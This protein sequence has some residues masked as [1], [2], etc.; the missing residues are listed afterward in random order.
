[1]LME[2]FYQLMA[3]INHAALVGD[4]TPDYG[5]HMRQLSELWPGARFLHI[6]RDGRDTA[7]S[8][9]G[10]LSFCYL[11]ASGETE[12]SKA[13]VNKAFIRYRQQVESGLPLD[14][15]FDLWR[16]RLS[17][18]RAEARRLPEDRYLEIRYEDLLQRPEEVL[19]QM[20]L[21]L[22]LAPEDN[23]ASRYRR[24]IRRGQRLIEP[25]LD[26][27]RHSDEF[28]QLT[29]KHAG[30]LAELGFEPGDF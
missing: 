19:Q 29:R 14:M 25:N 2:G 30:T 28:Q 20:G 18:I 9:A 7:L 26:K 27:N 21:F 3:R 12:W 22:G 8:M 10:N 16:R 5:F 24:W 4:K 17:E 11:A 6:C 23:G 1:M 13:S 15:F